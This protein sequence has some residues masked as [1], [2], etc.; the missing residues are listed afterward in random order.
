MAVMAL[1]AQPVVPRV[2]AHLL[3]L[4]AMAAMVGTD[5]APGESAATVVTVVMA[6]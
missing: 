6:R 3:E 4:A 1:L 5:L 2:A